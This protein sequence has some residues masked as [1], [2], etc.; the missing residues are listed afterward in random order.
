[1]KK[2]RLAV[3]L[4]LSLL[5]IYLILWTP[6]PTEVFHGEE[7]L[8]GGVF[9]H[10]RLDFKNLW[11]VMSEASLL[12]LLLAFLLNPAHVLVRGHRW[13]LMVSPLGKLKT[14]DS[15]SL[16]MVGYLATAVLPLRIGEVARGLLLARRMDISKSSALATVI[17]ER[18]LDVLSFLVILALVG[19]VFPFPQSLR[20]GADI[21]TGG[22]IVAGAVV[23]YLTFRKKPSASR[24][25]VSAGSPGNR[26]KGFI[27]GA[28]SRFSAGFV[29]PTGWGKLTLVI[30][31]TIALWTI[32]TVQGYLVLLAFHFDRDVPA[33]AAAP[34]LAAAV[35]LVV[36]TIGTSIPSAPGAVGTFHAVCIFGLSLLG[37]APEPAAGYAV[38][39]HAVAAVFYIVFG[40]P[41]MWREGLHLTDLARIN[42]EA[43]GNSRPGNGSG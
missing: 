24:P 1:M 10:P 36:N 33:I 6:K 39:V 19:L 13:T 35:V 11:Q 5:F 42:R 12:P 38:V 41:Y 32:Y 2:L 8:W 3:G 26:V 31:E 21:F 18:M 22:A 37:V 30:A 27:N 20:R 40:I 16:Q 4:G 25:A 28:I 34:F 15:C 9:G 29:F 17:I 14:R 43:H 23:V 7:S